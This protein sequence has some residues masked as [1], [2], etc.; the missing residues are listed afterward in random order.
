MPFVTGMGH[1][2][3][4]SLLAVSCLSPN[5]TRGL[6]GIGEARSAMCGRLSSKSQREVIAKL[7][8]AK[9]TPGDHF[10]SYNVAP[11]ESA[12]IVRE[13]ADQERTVDMAKFGIPT[14]APGRSFLLINL[15]S[16]KAPTRK[17][18]KERRCVIPADGF[19]EWA[20][21]S[22]RSHCAWRGRAEQRPVA[23]EERPR[24]KT[25]LLAPGNKGLGRRRLD[26]FAASPF[27]FHRR[28]HLRLDRLQLLEAHHLRKRKWTWRKSARSN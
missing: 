22:A 10:P 20:W 18:F 16:E 15:K 17:D 28:E 26:N 11:T 25:L 27:R 9:V 12:P 4:R 8:H 5:H 3:V 14:T 1:H 13:R 19:Y 7:Y 23:S 24:R 21:A 2:A 6:C